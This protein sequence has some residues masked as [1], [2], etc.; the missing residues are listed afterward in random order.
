MSYVS[1]PFPAD[2]V[3]GAYHRYRPGEPDRAGPALAEDPQPAIRSARH[4]FT[5]RR[6]Y[7]GD[8]ALDRR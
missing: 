2:A 5:W 7:R 6:V 8:G 3:T 1:A 4:F